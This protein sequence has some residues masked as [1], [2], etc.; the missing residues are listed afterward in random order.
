[1]VMDGMA[2]TC[3]RLAFVQAD[4]RAEYAGV[5]G[6][7]TPISKLATS[8]SVKHVEQMIIVVLASASVSACKAAKCSVAVVCSNVAAVDWDA[9][10]C[11][12]M[13]RQ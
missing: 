9:Y 10:G 13:S 5:F 12:H 4:T 11:M 1:M 8:N 6:R 2:L 7:A 3:H